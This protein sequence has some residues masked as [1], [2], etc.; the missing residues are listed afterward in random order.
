MLP[1]TYIHAQQDSIQI[2]S[3]DDSI[4]H[5]TTVSGNLPPIDSQIIDNSEAVNLMIQSQTADM[6]TTFKETVM[7]GLLENTENARQRRELEQQMD[8]LR[9]EDSLRRAMQKHRID[10]LK[11]TAIGAPVI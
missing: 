7:A 4:E 10:S 9:N 1:F 11:R 2:P 8:I 6:E 5:R 3:I